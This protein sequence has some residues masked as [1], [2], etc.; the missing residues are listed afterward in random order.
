MNARHAQPI[1]RHFMAL[2]GLIWGPSLWAFV[3]EDL[4]NPAAPLQVIPTENPSE[5]SRPLME[6]TWQQPRTPGYK[7]DAFQIRP[8]WHSLEWGAAVTLDQKDFSSLAHLGLPFGPYIKVLGGILLD[9][10]ESDEIKAERYRLSYGP[11][12]QAYLHFP[13]QSVLT[14][15]FAIGTGYFFTKT[16]SQEDDILRDQS[17]GFLARLGI[18]LFMTRQFSVL[19][20]W[21]ALMMENIV[22]QEPNIESRK[23]SRSQIMFQFTI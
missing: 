10:A 6:E 19:I 11:T 3:E 20:Q 7:A 15:F 9:S 21:S 12:F 18:D 16:T 23:V 13:N 4:T 14:P 2:L 5:S 8:E 17:M 1:F 22:P